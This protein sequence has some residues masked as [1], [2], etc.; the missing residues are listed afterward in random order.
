M[1]SCSLSEK[2]IEAASLVV[3]TFSVRNSTGTFITLMHDF[4]QSC[5]AYSG[6]AALVD[7]HPIP[8]SFLKNEVVRTLSNET[9]WKT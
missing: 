4:P 6:I 7:T 8:P 3:K 9:S 5:W 1:G 2:L